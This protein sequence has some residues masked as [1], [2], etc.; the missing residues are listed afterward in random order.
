MRSLSNQIVVGRTDIIKERSNS[1]TVDWESCVV[2]VR[3]ADDE[4]LRGRL[5][6]LPGSR[7][8]GRLPASS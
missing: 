1:R 3:I 8:V 7:I 6:R 5:D 4:I 2:R